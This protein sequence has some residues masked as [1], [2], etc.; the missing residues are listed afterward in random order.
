M[1]TPPDFLSDEA[2]V[3]WGRVIDTLYNVGLM[4]E[5]DRAALAAY[6]Q[7]YGNWAR[8][9]RQI[10]ELRKGGDE[11]GGVLVATDKGNLIQHP[12]FGIANKAKADVIR[13]AGEFGMTPAARSRVEAH[14]PEEKVS[15]AKKFF[16]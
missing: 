8:A 1:P 7:A 11:L 10:A 15:K 16:G 14:E 13:Y 12:L 4:T 6:C 5:L 9:E 2:K 3:E